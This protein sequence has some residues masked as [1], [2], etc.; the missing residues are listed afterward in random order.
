[1][2]F[3]ALTSSCWTTRVELKPPNLK[4]EGFNDPKGSSRML[5]LVYQKTMF[6]LY[7]RIVILSLETLEN[8]LKSSFLYYYN[9]A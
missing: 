9:G 6:D 1:M 7:Y 8:A 4:G 3:Y 2:F 5:V